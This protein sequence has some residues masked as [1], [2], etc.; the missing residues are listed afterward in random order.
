MEIPDNVKQGLEII[1]VETAD[2]VLARALAAPVEPVEWTES[3]AAALAGMANP[4]PDGSE[5]QLAH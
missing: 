1:P 3:D 2:E 4:A 5:A